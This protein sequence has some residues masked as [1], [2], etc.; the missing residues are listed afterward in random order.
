MFKIAFAFILIIFASGNLQARF[1][2]HKERSLGPTGLFGIT[3]PTSITITKVSEGSPAAGKLKP[4]DVL[5]GAG[6]TPFKGA[7]RKQLADAID[8]AESTR[9]RGKLNLLLKG[10]KTVALQLPVLGNYAKTAPYNC[11]KTDAIITRTA[12]FMVKNK[13]F[14][15]GKMHIGLLGLLATGEDKYIK[16]V[17]GFLHSA[18]WAKPDHKVTETK[19]WHLAYTSILLCEY[20]LLTEDEYILPAIKNHAVHAA[21]GR[22]AGGLWGHPIA[23]DGRLPGYAQMNC[24]SAPMFLSLALAE[25]CGIS[26]PEITACLA[27]NQTFYKGFVG[28]GAIPYGVHG[29]VSN[30]F[31]DNGKGAAVA[32][33]FAATGNKEGA[34]FF[35]ILA[36]AGHNALETGHTGHFLNQ[37]WTGL[38]ADI[39]GPR[40]TAA[41]FKETR[42]LHTMNRT[43]DGGFTYDGCGYKYATFTYRGMSD[44]GSHLLNYCRGRNKIYI[45][46]K[47]ADPSLW[48]SA[49]EVEEAIKL[50]NYGIDKKSE[51]ELLALFSHPMPQI[52]RQAI[53]TLRSKKH[54]YNETI[55]KM[56]KTGTRLQRLSACSY[57]GYGCPPELSTPSLED[58]A[59]ILQNQKEDPEIRAAAASVFAHCGPAGKKYF[60]LILSVILEDKPNDPLGYLDEQ[61]VGSLN[62]LTPNA[63]A[64][65]LVTDKKLFYAA[66]DKILKHKRHSARSQGGQLI[67]NL[68]IEDFHLVADSSLAI[69]KDEDRTYHSYHGLG[70]QTNIIEMFA[71]LKIEGGIEAAYEILEKPG[72]KAGFKLRLLMSVIPKYGAN[73]KY[74]LP[75]IKATHAGKFQ[76]RWDAMAKEIEASSGQKKMRSFE[77]AKAIGK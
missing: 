67:K 29:P 77:E 75:K 53:W 17:R 13:K 14:G 54:T 51:K 68:P 43:W 10:N 74:A 48:L 66:A 39:S 16:V 62:A 18:A 71:K 2:E 19:A 69:I 70:P 26:H 32:H 1:F 23:T 35:S 27:Q 47:N 4:G 65:K 7:T 63:F 8:Q 28:K 42:W 9:G 3:S 60:N 64:D 49:E 34:R 46:G 58:F 76:R 57:F 31:S 52:R 40:A 38:G 5:I 24:T 41:F 20:Y 72:G 6:N 33:A 45:T 50:P 73:A 21:K 22:D 56:I 12:D 37:L 25:K 44:E 59:K 36:I 55:R 30:R 61:L 15:R 11:K